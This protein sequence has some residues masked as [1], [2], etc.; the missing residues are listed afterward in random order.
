MRAGL[1][2]PRE[3][4]FVLYLELNAKSQIVSRAINTPVHASWRPRLDCTS[5]VLCTAAWHGRS[6]SIRSAQ[7]QMGR[8]G[9]GSEDAS[10]LR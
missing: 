5:R 9:T 4:L 3:K 2:T 1:A 7:T 10:A 6:C 8:D